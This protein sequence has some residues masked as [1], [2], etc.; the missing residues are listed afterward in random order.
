MR[1]FGWGLCFLIL[2]TSCENKKSKID[3]FAAITHMV[4]SVTQDTD[5]IAPQVQEDKTPK[6]IEADESFDDFIFNYASND[7]L[8]RQRTK[9]P[10]PYYNGDTPTKIDEKY[11]KHGEN[12]KTFSDVYNEVI[13]S[14]SSEYNFVMMG[15][16]ETLLVQPDV[17]ASLIP[18]F[19]FRQYD[20]FR[21]FIFAVQF[22]YA[23]GVVYP[24]IVLRY[25][26]KA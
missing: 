18:N 19:F 2:F 17:Y 22:V 24:N 6:P 9:F 13:G 14:L 3:P 12:L 8:Q 26:N 11:W 1:K 10:L 16:M 25:K 15:D 21:H 20:F 7:V 4:D 23:D 5:S